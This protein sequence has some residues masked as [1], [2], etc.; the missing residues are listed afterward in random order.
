MAN[1]KRSALIVP[2]ADLSLAINANADAAPITLEA[3]GVPASEITAGAINTTSGLASNQVVDSYAQATAGSADFN[4]TGLTG[5]NAPSDYYITIIDVT[6]GREAFPRR[7]FT[8]PTLS[9][10][11]D[12]ID[13]ATLEAGDGKAYQ[14][15]INSN[16]ITVQ[17]PD[18]V[19]AKVAATDGCTITPSAPVLQ[20]GYTTAQ[21]AEYLK[22]VVTDQFGRTN[23]V[24]FPVIEP[25]VMSALTEASSTATTWDLHVF[26][27]VS[28][29][30]FDKNTASS[31]QDVETFELFVPSGTGA[32]A[33]EVAADD[34][35]E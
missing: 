33:N 23:R 20:K 24:K 3:M 29:V 18:N 25:N 31:Y 22:D 30:M 32:F 4:F 6:G 16:T 10:L 21:A 13:A 2:G 1:T 12:A 8:A 14:A 15:S 27:K 35:G 17:F 5:A 9:A 11:K 28:E 19:I 7:T 26:T 34:G